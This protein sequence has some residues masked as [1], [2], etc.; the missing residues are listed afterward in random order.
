MS[1]QFP[2]YLVIKG[3]GSPDRHSAL[4]EV[5]IFNSLPMS[6]VCRSIPSLN[7][8]VFVTFEETA[9]LL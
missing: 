6:H 3:L 8:L 5:Y 9:G 1:L 2:G 4:M 7:I